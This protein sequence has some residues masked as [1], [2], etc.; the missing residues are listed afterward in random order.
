M[1]AIIDLI[2]TFG[3]MA[4]KVLV[5]YTISVG[6]NDKGSEAIG[7]WLMNQ[8]LNC[9]GITIARVEVPL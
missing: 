1:S 2:R 8:V 5:F 7:F 3:Q 4:K 9:L 6:R